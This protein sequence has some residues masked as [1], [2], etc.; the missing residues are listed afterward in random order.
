MIAG[1]LFLGQNEEHGQPHDRPGCSRA[2]LSRWRRGGRARDAPCK[3]PGRDMH[4]TEEP[5]HRNQME[6][7][8]APPAAAP[9]GYIAANTAAQLAPGSG[10]AVAALGPGGESLP[11]DGGTFIATASD[12][13]HDDGGALYQTKAGSRRV[14]TLVSARHDCGKLREAA[15]GAESAE[16][17]VPRPAPRRRRRHLPPAIGSSARTRRGPTRSRDPRGG[18]CPRTQKRG[19]PRGNIPRGPPLRRS[20]VHRSAAPCSPTGFPRSTIGAGRLSFRV[21]NGT[22]RAPAARTADRWAALRPGGAR[23]PLRAAQRVAG[24]V[25]A[26]GAIR[27]K[28]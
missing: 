1:A 4:E 16:E 5:M 21:R 24:A 10:A 28:S 17:R 25:R 12:R 20:A 19:G 9:I 27:V 15:R 7:G 13:R 11:K 22:G 3:P 14:R 8:A 23:V 6:C 2:R 18:Q 26:S